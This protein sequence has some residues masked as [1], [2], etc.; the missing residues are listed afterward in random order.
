MD[1]NRIKSLAGMPQKHEDTATLRELTEA[2]ELPGDMS[3]EDAIK[4]LDAC[5]RA[6]SIVHTLKDPAEKKKWMS[7]TFVNL[8]K[9][10]A[11]VKRLAAETGVAPKATPTQP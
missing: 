1:I 10:S 11:A 8:N 7:A 6:L 2:V 4:R 3:L 9:V 5:K